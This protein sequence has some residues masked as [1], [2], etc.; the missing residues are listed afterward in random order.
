[1]QKDDCISYTKSAD[2]QCCQANN[3]NDNDEKEINSQFNIQ[4]STNFEQLSTVGGL[5][6]SPTKTSKGG[7]GF[8]NH[9]DQISEFAIITARN[10]SFSQETEL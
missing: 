8:S 4:Y 10:R 3:K 9:G 5:T 2:D 1:M 6:E 7:E